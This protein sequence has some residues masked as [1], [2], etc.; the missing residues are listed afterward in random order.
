VSPLL[1]GV[2][3]GVIGA[4]TFSAPLLASWPTRLRWVLV[5][6]TMDP[7]GGM[8]AWSGVVMCEVAIVEVS[9]QADRVEVTVA[10]GRGGSSMRQRRLVVHST[11]PGLVAQ[12]E[13]WWTVR[14]PL[15]LT[16]G[17]S[18]EAHLA[19]PGATLTG[20]REASHREHRHRTA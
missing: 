11:A 12:L 7:F 3:V 17:G 8:P 4:L 5:A 9:V 14:L 2:M 16:S 13:G 19:G 6:Q 20:F 18:G 10:E 15:L 1:L